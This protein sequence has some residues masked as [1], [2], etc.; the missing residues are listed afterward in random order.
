MIIYKK[1]I[2]LIVVF[3]LI[4]LVDTQKPEEN[5]YVYEARIDTILSQLTLEE[6][7]A[8]LHG[9]SLFSSP[10]V[11]RLEIPD[12]NYSDGPHGVRE[13][14]DKNFF[15][16]AGL[17]TD[18][19]TFFPTGTAL[20]ATW[21]SYLAEEYGKALG[22]EARARGKDILLGPGVNIIR[23]PLCGR[24]YEYY[25][26]DPFLN[27][28][29]AVAYIRGVQSN[30][31][32]A[33]IKHYLG[34]NQEEF[35]GRIDVQMDER[36]L[37]EIY[38]PVY[39]AAVQE[40][41]IWAFMGAYNKF[42]G[43]YCCENKYLLNDILKEEW[44]FKGIVISDWGATHS[45]IGSAENGLDVEMGTYRRK[46]Q[47][48]YFGKPLLDSL[49]NG[50]MDKQLIDDKI[51]RILRVMNHCKT[52]DKNRKKGSINTPEHSRI[53][54]RVAR[55]SVV[56]LKNDLKLLPLDMSTIRSIAVIG[57]NA[58]RT[59]ATGGFSAA[60]KARY[61][62]TP[63]QGLQNKSKG[64]INIH[65][66]RG[67]EKQSKWVLK[68]WRHTRVENDTLNEILLTEAVN[69]AAK[70]DLAIIFAG[71]N[72]DYDTETIDRPYMKLPYAQDQVIKS[73]AAANP[74][75]I[76][77]L[78]AGS[79]VDLAD[80]IDRVPAVLWGWYNGSE[81]GN[82]IADIL[83]GNV[84]PSGKLP[85]TIPKTLTDSP[86]H[87]LNAYPGDTVLVQYKEGILVGYRWFD[88]KQISPLFCFGHGLSYT[89]FTYSL[90][91]TDKK[92]Y[93][94]N[95]EIK[96][97]FN[98]KNSGNIAGAEAVQLYINDLECSVD[99]PAKELK[100]FKKVFLQPGEEQ[101]IIIT[102][103]IN[104]L[105]FFDDEKM[106]W[107]VEPGKFNLMIASSSRDIRLSTVITVK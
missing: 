86:A 32:A 21:N 40:A 78:I 72:H 9:N 52:M 11:E 63:L 73:I 36:A 54:Y 49:N 55:E 64:K 29:I 98:L 37:R 25:S 47:D 31:I 28:R 10:G 95:E 71:L 101:K 90:L 17:T 93:T 68:G 23:T 77:V 60:V 58:T 82:A 4:T 62:I 74:R 33:C 96:I 16:P 45:T 97:S 6:K 19:A 100:G 5:E 65:F 1:Q 80:V 18:S 83:F 48:Y 46:N 15:R 94:M 22:E 12:L 81:G 99:R 43:F 20:A 75:T 42:R 35:R 76:V 34:N 53:A 57:D 8:M 79:P 92:T 70:S 84:N 39:K 56:L 44:D 50:K 107:V 89:N 14:Q 13:E 27:T 3:L 59:H 105:A 85:F 104:D 2:I 103:H 67:Y 24:N 106:E 51:R 102:S 66:A 87:F 38:F 26:E 88:T 91:E 7:I 61:E 30:D 41:N 69:A